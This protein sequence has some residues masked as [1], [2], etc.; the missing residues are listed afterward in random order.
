M[1]VFGREGSVIFHILTPYRDNG[2]SFG[3]LS[4]ESGTHI[5]WRNID[6][7]YFVD[8]AS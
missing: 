2:L 3:F 6:K 7:K 4:P 5:L 1:L 8:R